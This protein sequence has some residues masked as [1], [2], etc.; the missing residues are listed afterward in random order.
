VNTG[1]S[2]TRIGALA[3]YAI[4]TF[5]TFPHE[6][7][8][9]S[10]FDFGLVVVWFGPAALLVGITGL[11]PGRAA[12]AAFFAS[13]VSHAGLFHWFYVVTVRYGGMPAWLGVLS[14]LVP[15]LY[16]SLFSALF[17]WTWIRYASKSRWPLVSGA[18]AWV[19]I[20][21]LRGHFLGGF[22]WATLGYG[23]HLDGP[24]MGWT[25][26]L[27]VY[28]L[29]FVAVLLGIAMARVWLCRDATTKR[30]LAFSVAFVLVAHGVGLWISQDEFD[31]S[32]TVRIAAVQGN[33]DQAKKWD[34][35]RRDRIFDRYARLSREAAERGATWIVWPETAVP[36][37]LEVDLTLRSAIRRLAKDLGVS[38]IVGG[39]GVE[40]D[41][42]SR[43]LSSFFDSA[44]LIDAKGEFQDRYDKTH[45]VPFGE[46][47]PL[48]AFFGR[49]FQ[50]LARGLSTTDITAGSA[51]RSI[52]IRATAASEELLGVGVPICYE[53]LFPHVVR[54]FGARGVGVLLAITNDAWYGRTGAPHQFLAMTAMRAAENGRWLVRAANTGISAIIDSRG[55]VRVTSPLFEEAVLVADIPVATRTAPT[56]YARFGD[57]FAW[58]CIFG[59]LVPFGR[60]ELD[61]R[62]RRSEERIERDG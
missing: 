20:D 45:L 26:W 61:A 52:L 23:L 25:R 48:R 46:F 4:L 10:A 33:I 22:P 21:W 2:W 11:S 55:R 37:L 47:V 16:V 41:P 53:L 31:S 59:S 42:R 3:L 24:L 39:T 30:A 7:L 29:S 34:A 12:R 43:R 18:M 13:L 28:G 32:V 62:K 57:V 51:P 1:L 56:F 15:A 54:Q 8:G 19:A 36:G 6:G 17:A 35:Q 5:L 14:P 58:L 44:F 50:S 40:F 49:F 38:L 60:K 9:G 27:G